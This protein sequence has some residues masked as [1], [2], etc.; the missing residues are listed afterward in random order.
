MKSSCPLWFIF[1]KNTWSAI[2]NFII[3]NEKFTLSRKIIIFIKFINGD[4]PICFREY[5]PIPDFFRGLLVGLGLSLELFGLIRIKQ[6]KKEGNSCYT[7]SAT[8]KVLPPTNTRSL[9]PALC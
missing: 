9:S 1:Y 3:E 5:V 4:L 6:L 8:T 2:F 7:I